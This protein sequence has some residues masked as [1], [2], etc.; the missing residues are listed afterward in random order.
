M[1]TRIVALDTTSEFG[2]I[3]LVEDGA[4]VEEVE[5]H[6]PE[7]F[8][9]VLFP[10]LQRLLQR[11]GW[12][13]E[14]VSGYAAASGPGSFTGVRIG[15]AAVK[16]LAEASGTRAAAVST[17]RAIASFGSA[18]V[19]AAVIDARRGEVYGAVFGAGLEALGEESVG[20]LER[21]LD[22]LPP[23]AEIVTTAPE[24]LGERAATL[25]PRALAAAIGRLA[26]GEL[27]DPAALDANYVRRSDAEL[28]WK[29]V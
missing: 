25:A 26:A 10:Q 17:L 29:E 19:R 21:W 13:W 27:A 1:K 23:G 8:G 12:R 20:P 6:S 9:H 3:A 28:F 2:S 15:L 4:T 11:H 16:G 14:L 7:G 22:S 24:L 5:I 18:E